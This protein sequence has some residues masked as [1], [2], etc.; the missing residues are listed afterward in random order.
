MPST[1]KPCVTAREP[2][3]WHSRGSAGAK[4][5]NVILNWFPLRFPSFVQAELAPLLSEFTLV[6][7]PL[8]VHGFH[9]RGRAGGRGGGS[10][11]RSTG[12]AP[13]NATKRRQVEFPQRG[14]VWEGRTQT[15]PSGQARR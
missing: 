14:D 12:A 9:G 6:H 3:P 5:I 10:R 13:G 7:M 2:Q 1:N 11:Q 8:F 15:N 4:E